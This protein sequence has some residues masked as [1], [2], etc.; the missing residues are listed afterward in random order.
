M[1]SSQ[2]TRLAQAI[3]WA[4]TIGLPWGECKTAPCVAPP[5]CCRA[6]PTASR[7]RSR[8]TPSATARRHHRQERRE[9]GQEVGIEIQPHPPHRCKVGNQR[10]RRLDLIRRQVPKRRR[11]PLRAPKL[12]TGR[13]A[14]Q[15]LHHRRIGGRPRKR[16]NSDPD[17]DDAST[18]VRLHR[19]DASTAS[20]PA[21][22]RGRQR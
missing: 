20:R 16:N 7:V 19:R 5:L 13:H 12:T 2:T 3:V 11:H 10:K 18:S 4:E 22:R 1:G 14:R 15:P 8:R 6:R 21:P 9:P 17:T